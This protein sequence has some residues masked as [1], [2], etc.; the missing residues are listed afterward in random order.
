M[1]KKELLEQAKALGLKP[2]TRNS[3]AELEAMIATATA[4]PKAPREAKGKKE[5]GDNPDIARLIEGIDTG[6]FGLALMH[7]ELTPGKLVRRS[8]S[9]RR[10]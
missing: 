3:V 1:S 8:V 7:R 5:T 2:V 4:K 10:S 9:N 6:D